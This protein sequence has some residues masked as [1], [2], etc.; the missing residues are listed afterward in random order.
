MPELGILGSGAIVSN[1]PYGN[2]FW[3]NEKGKSINWAVG[4]DDRWHFAENETSVRRAQG[5]ENTSVE[6]RMRVPGGDIVQR[7]DV[8]PVGI[9][10]AVLLEFENET[11][12]PVAIAI[13]A[14]NFKTLEI[15]GSKVSGE[16]GQVI[17]A[18]K[19]IALFCVSDDPQKLNETIQNGLAEPPAKRQKLES[20]DSAAIIFPL[21]HATSLRLLI[22]QDGV[23]EL[24]DPKV[25][26]SF[27]EISNGWRNHLDAG[28][29]IALPDKQILN[30][31]DSSKKHLL[32]GSGQPID[33]E[34][35]GKEKPG[36]VASL[37]ALAL[38]QWGHLKEGKDLLLKCMELS[39]PGLFRKTVLHST[40]ITL[41][42]WG[43]Y[44]GHGPSD[45]IANIILPWVKENLQFLL[46]SLPSKRRL[47][48]KD[49]NLE[50]AALQASV[51]ILRDAGQQNLASDVATQLDEIL[52]LINPVSL[53]NAD[54]E[55]RLVGKKITGKF[56]NYFRDQETQIHSQ[57]TVTDLVNKADRT[58][59]FSS[60]DRSQDPMSSALF[61][62][63]ARKAFI[64]DEAA[65]NG[66]RFIQIAEGFHDNWIGAS[67]E[68]SNAPIR[69]GKLGFAI[70]WHGAAPAVLWEATTD[71]RITISAPKLDISWLT[72]DLKGETL[73]AKQELPETAVTIF[74]SKKISL[75]VDENNLSEGPEGKP[76]R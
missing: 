23:P 63:L 27:S 10:S 19:P 48:G 13:K 51:E 30:A 29:Q 8:I 75:H 53:A 68:V 2:L 39:N 56:E 59:A 41:W 47:K 26:P 35:W 17:S 1:D 32:I 14:I 44:I 40:L 34:F 60:E 3:L 66:N 62:I 52:E 46:A 69:G 55:Y 70:R 58:G 20:G 6:I 57:L 42:A 15:N 64:I 74:E 28:M 5:D 76:F 54:D 7:T 33:S 16:F 18:S 50:I 37:S 67:L 11:P 12:V 4:A 61:L 24:P 45:G 36:E 49:L 31:V 43:N 73:L 38:L 72:H 21:P 65:A 71:S 25:S 9:D 22:S